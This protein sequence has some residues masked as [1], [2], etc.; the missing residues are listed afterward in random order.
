MYRKTLQTS[1]AVAALF[2]FAAPFAGPASAA[3]KNIVSSGSKVHIAIT[4]QVGR[5]VSI[6]DDGNTTNIHHTNTNFSGTRVR[7]VGTA[8][9]WDN[10]TIGTRIEF[11]FDSRN[12]NV[13]GNDTAGAGQDEDQGDVNGID[14]RYQ[15]ITFAGSWGKFYIGKVDSASNGTAE[16]DLSG[17]NI[18]LDVNVG[19]AGFGGSSFIIS[20][21]AAGVSQDPNVNGGLA[22]P[23][24]STVFT[25]FDGLSR[26]QRVR[27]DTPN[28]GGFKVSVGL[29]QGPIPDAA[30]RY[31]GSFAGTKVSLAIAW[32]NRDSA[33]LTQGHQIDGSASILHSS[34]LS[35][36]IAGGTREIE[37]APVGRDDPSFIYAKLGYKA[38]LIGAGTTN[39]YVNYQNTEDLAAQGD[40]AT[41]WGFGVVQILKDYATEL[42]A[43]FSVA[44]LDDSTLNTYDDLVTGLVGARL[45]F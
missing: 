7:F 17:T 40:D 28:F 22:G 35:L 2:A 21:L 42:F 24:A 38:K 9:A 29:N 27:Y 19:N 33:N 14:Q 3:N 20:N 36:T 39:F 13:S 41:Y 43:A 44:D 26:T 32:A 37:P 18:A 12:S 31:V 15:D 8:K 1:V 5:V 30:I 11:Q 4:G 25:N 23:R 45:K 16:V 34:G 10:L 6:V